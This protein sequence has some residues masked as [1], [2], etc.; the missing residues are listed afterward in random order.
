M[1]EPHERGGTC[2]ST[3]T[4][5]LCLVVPPDN[6]P[7][8]QCDSETKS[9]APMLVVLPDFLRLCLQDSAVHIDRLTQGVGQLLSALTL[10]KHPIKNSLSH[11]GILVLCGQVL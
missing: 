3:L 1:V 11:L 5:L 4:D 9:V 7:I 2:A 10:P 8:F 6:M